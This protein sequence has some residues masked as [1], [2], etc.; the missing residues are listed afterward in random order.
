MEELAKRVRAASYLTGEFRLRSGNISNFYWDKY[1]FESDPKLL[2]DIAAEMAKRLPPRCDGLAGLEL[3]GVPLATAISLQ[4]GIPCYYVRK[5]AKNYGTC[6]L[7]E[8]GA[9]E[10]SHLVVIEDVITTAG[11]V[12]TSIAQ[13]RAAGYVAEHVIAV[14]DR[15]AGGAEK[16]EALGCSL[17]SVF[18]LAALNA[19]CASDMRREGK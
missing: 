17:T 2:A 15:Q 13:I 19:D 16:I 5:E 12:C 14:I 4:T 6:N 18:T 9:E 11:Q 3:G 8:G 7:I 1:R 10:G